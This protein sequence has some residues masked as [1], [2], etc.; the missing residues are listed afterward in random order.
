MPSFPAWPSFW[1]I[2]YKYAKFSVKNQPFH[3]GPTIRFWGHKRILKGC[4]SPWW[5]WPMLTCDP[6]RAPVQGSTSTPEPRVRLAQGLAGTVDLKSLWYSPSALVSPPPFLSQCPSSNA[7][8]L[9]ICFGC[10]PPVASLLSLGT[11]TE[12]GSGAGDPLP[13]PCGGLIVCPPKTCWVLTPGT[14]ECNLTWTQGI[15]AMSSEDEVT[16]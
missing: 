15:V 13:F 12:G 5:F 2:F 3:I 9:N 11:I 10:R 8:G 4:S 7:G 14:S 6:P 16:G 1:D